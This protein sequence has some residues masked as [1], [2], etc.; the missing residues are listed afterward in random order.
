VRYWNVKLRALGAAHEEYQRQHTADRLAFDETERQRILALATDFL[1]IWACPRGRR[2]AHLPSSRRSFLATALLAQP[3]L[4][5]Q[6]QRH[7]GVSVRRVRANEPRSLT[8]T[9]NAG[10][11]SPDTPR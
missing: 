9:V 2:R 10:T 1:A 7:F 4:R 11:C 8:A 3:T 6:D 5:D